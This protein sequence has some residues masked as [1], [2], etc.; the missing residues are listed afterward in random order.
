MI[1]SLYEIYNLNWTL[2]IDLLQMKKVFGPHMTHVDGAIIL[3]PQPDC[4]GA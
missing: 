4:L 3:E 1:F 2:F